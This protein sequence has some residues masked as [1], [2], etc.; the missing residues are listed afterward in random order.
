MYESVQSLKG[1][2]LSEPDSHTKSASL[3]L[4]PG[5]HTTA[6][7]AYL[8]A[9]AAVSK[10]KHRTKTPLKSIITNTASESSRESEDDHMTNPSRP[11]PLKL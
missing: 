1:P 10:K 7:L 2:S 11:T 4:G 9:T 6:E 3:A 5:H 8:Q